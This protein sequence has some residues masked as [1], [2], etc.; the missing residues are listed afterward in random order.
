MWVAFANT[1]ATQIF[2]S[3]NVSV[4]AIFNDQSFNDT[5]TTCNDIIRFEQLGP[6]NWP[7]SYGLASEIIK[8]HFQRRQLSELFCHLLK[9]RKNLPQ[10]NKFFLLE[11]SIFRRLVYCRANR[12]KW[13]KIYIVYP[14]WMLTLVLERWYNI[15]QHDPLCVCPCSS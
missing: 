8:R 5:L 1:I 10:R 6:G 4:Y 9:K 12:E 11:Y 3:K 2:S 14:W 7:S 15:W 13:W